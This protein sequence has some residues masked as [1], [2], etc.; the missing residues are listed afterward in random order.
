MNTLPYGSWPSPIAAAD[1]AGAAIGLDY[2]LVDDGQVYWTEG[3]AQQGGRVALWCLRQDG[4]SAELVP[5]HSV[6]SG[7]NEYGGGAWTVAAG[8]L[9]FSSQASG[10]LWAL[11]DGVPRRI[12]EGGRY[13]YGCLALDPVRRLVLAVREDHPPT[14]GPCQQVLVAVGLDQDGT[15]VPR[16]LVEGADFYASPAISPDGLLAWVQ[17]NLPDMPWEAS[18]LLIAPIDDPSQARRVAG[19]PGNSVVHPQWADDGALVYLDDRSGYWNFQSWDGTASRPLHDHAADFCYPPWTPGPA[20]YSLLPDGR[21]ACSWYQDGFATG[22]ILSPASAGPPAAG[23]D[24]T[25]LPTGAVSC[26][27]TGRGNLVVALLGYPD[28]PAE[29]RLL[30]LA[31]DTSLLLRSA[32]QDRLPAGMASV[33]RPITWDS[34]DGPVHAWFYPPRHP[35]CV[36]PTGEVPPVQVWSHGGPTGYS[37][38]AFRL[39]TQYWTSRGI[40]ILDVNYS[41]S[42]GYGRA[43]RER[44]TGQWGISDVRDAVGCVQTLVRAGLADPKRLS[45]RGGS[46]GGFTTLAALTS[47]DVFAA[48]VSL[49]GIADLEAMTDDTHKFESRYLDRL[50]AP[51]PQERTTYVARSPIH[52]L[53]HLTCPMLIVQG[54]K[55]VVVPPQQAEDLAKAVRAKGLEAELI[56]FDQEGHMF[57]RSESIIAIAKAALAFLGRVHGFVPAVTND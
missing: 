11:E 1:L 31:A 6:R 56:M 48:G 50:V 39:D 22:G 17:W 55:D 57:R 15:A 37:S 33:A 45:I 2:G 42:A 23:G 40:G 27:I 5:D 24:L 3:Y 26:T 9:V 28:R 8:I 30:D 4:T 53:D 51:Y 36:A 19:G 47:T 29:L 7:I 54:R 20:P 14:G 13:R 16:I 18:Q 46:A 38:P 44:L 49:C 21:I 32:G 35:D 52:H 10:E 12:A 43:Y 34:P 25:E 41:G